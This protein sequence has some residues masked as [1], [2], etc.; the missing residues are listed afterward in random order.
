M[1][2]NSAKLRFQDLTSEK[3]LALDAKQFIGNEYIKKLSQ[4]KRLMY[5]EAL[6]NYVSVL[7]MCE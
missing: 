2:S 3:A 6:R 7:N 1:E 4:K 5:H